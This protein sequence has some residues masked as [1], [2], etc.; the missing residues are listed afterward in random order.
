ML[1]LLNLPL[2]IFYG[3]RDL[4]CYVDFQSF[5][6]TCRTISMV[7]QKD[8]KKLLIQKLKLHTDEPEKLLDIIDQTKG[9]ISGSFIL[10][11]L[12]DQN[13]YN[14]IDIYENPNTTIPDDVYNIT[15]FSPFSE[16]E[17]LKSGISIDFSC[18]DTPISNYIRTAL[19]IDPNIDS[20]GYSMICSCVKNY[21]I[22]QHILIPFNL[23]KF[24]LNYYD[25]DLCSNMYYGGQLYV[26]S[27]DKLFSKVDYL[28][29]NR[30]IGLKYTEKD[31]LEYSIVSK[32]VER[33]NQYYKMG[34]VIKL[35]PNYDK[36]L[37]CLREHIQQYDKMHDYKNH[38]EL[39]IVD[40]GEL[41]KFK[42]SKNYNSDYEFQK[43]LEM[44]EDISCENV[45]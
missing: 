12:Y 32:L 31:I 24:I 36:M 30:L 23:P 22:F 17:S 9:C 14:D 13:F 43:L 29:P 21:K 25:I 35:H 45:K 18:Q 1:H 20:R 3:F 16:D 11:V 8:F 38:K 33:K 15:S 44:K 42:E 5:R 10:A 2:E 40:F 6:L 34:F 27:W 7:Q 39:M 19:N 26:K 37:K 4:L 41:E 28:K